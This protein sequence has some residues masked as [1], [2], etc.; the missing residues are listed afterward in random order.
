MRSLRSEVSARWWSSERSCVKGTRV[1]AG[2]RVARLVIKKKHS[3]PGCNFCVSPGIRKRLNP[4]YTLP[5]LKKNMYLTKQISKSLPLD[6]YCN[7]SYDLV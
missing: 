1:V 4:I 3:Q 2:D 5:G 6:S 7:E